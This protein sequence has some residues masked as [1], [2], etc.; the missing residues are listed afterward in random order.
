MN[1]ADSDIWDMQISRQWNWKSFNKTWSLPKGTHLLSIE[2][3]EQVYL[4]QI[5]LRVN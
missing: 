4:D 2:Y 1:G 3:R 5:E